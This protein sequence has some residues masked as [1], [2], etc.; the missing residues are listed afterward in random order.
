MSINKNNTSPTETIVSIPID[1]LKNFTDHPFSIRDDDAMQQTVESVREYGV[2]VPAIARP[3]E[4]G[5]FELI[6][7]HRR[8]H[9]C[10]LAGLKTMPV[11]VRDIDR[12]TAV[13]MMVDISNIITNPIYMGKIRRGWS[14]QIKTIE[15]GEVVR[16]IKRKKNIEDYNVYEGLHEGL[17]TEEQ[18]TLAQE[19][20]LEKQ[21]AAKVKDE[22]ELQNAFVGLLFCS[23]CG[24]RIGRTTG[25]KARDARARLRC[26]NGRNC[27]NVSSDYDVVEKEIISALREW[28]KG[29][30]IKIDTVGYAKDIETLKNQNK[31][32]AT[33]LQKLNAQLENAYNLVEQGVYTLEIFKNRQEKLNASVSE[34][35]A[36][37]SENEITIARMEQSDNAKANLIPQTETLLAS[38]DEMSNEERNALLKEILKKIEYKKEANGKIEIDLYPRL[39]KI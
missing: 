14:Q 11:I 9:A 21:P 6:S 10:E 27:H 37:V 15:N 31:K 30:R 34:V 25:S 17:I 39:P 33:D 32:Y 18:F 22:F 19:I 12:N 20:R 3:L 1:K 24:K 2:L 7:G 13:I 5:T 29:Y 35:K 4:D 23:T 26:V 38:Y 28:L 8:K 36:K 16:K